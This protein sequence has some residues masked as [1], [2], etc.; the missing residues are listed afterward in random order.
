MEA[1][2]ESADIEHADE[3]VDFDIHRPLKMSVRS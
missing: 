2:D 1:V 3:A